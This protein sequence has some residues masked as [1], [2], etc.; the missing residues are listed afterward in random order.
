M[1]NVT[2][3]RVVLAIGVLLLVGAWWISTGHDLFDSVN[4]AA[5]G[6]GGLTLAFASFLIPA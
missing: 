3:A 1:K 4:A 2:V 6:Y 5:F